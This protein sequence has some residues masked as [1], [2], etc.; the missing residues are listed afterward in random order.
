MVLD[1]VKLAACRDKIAENEKVIADQSSRL[2]ELEVL[3]ASQQRLTWQL[4]AQSSIF[5][6][7]ASMK[8]GMAAERVVEEIQACL[9]RLYDPKVVALIPKNQASGHSSVKSLTSLALGHLSEPDK[10]S[11]VLVVREVTAEAG[12]NS[13]VDGSGFG[14]FL[15][16]KLRV[17]E[18]GLI[19]R[20]GDKAGGF[21]GNFEETLVKSLFDAAA[22]AV[23]K[24][25][26]KTKTNMALSSLG[27]F[28]G[29]FEKAVLEEKEAEAWTVQPTGD[30][31]VDGFQQSLAELSVSS[32]AV[33]TE[34]YQT[35]S[36]AN[37]LASKLD[38][39]EA[40]DERKRLLNLM[41][42]SASAACS[43]CLASVGEAGAAGVLSSGGEQRRGSGARSEATKRCE[44][45]GDSL[46]SSQHL[47][48]VIN[49]SSFATCFA[50]RSFVW[51]AY[52]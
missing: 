18:D 36:L 14:S 37:S 9:G 13:V 26:I 11:A 45:P 28:S 4:D 31:A 5:A 15:F 24:H 34:L 50:L 19:L 41:V 39:H 33:V 27:A 46:S 2:E 52:F 1:R 21:S 20:I 22:K 49:T 12:Y 10:A 29:S 44:Y 48:N 51:G 23:K 32:T 35:R 43:K 40:A 6:L 8:D 30:G 25:E 7:V 47:F 16:A 42:A 3:K 17:S 38:K